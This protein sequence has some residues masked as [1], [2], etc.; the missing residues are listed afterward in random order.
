MSTGT[1]LLAL[2]DIDLALARDRAELAAMP[3]IAELAKKRRA[4]QKLKSDATKLYAQRKDLETYLA[5]LD[6]AESDAN[7]D[8]AI[9][10]RHTDTSDYRG[11]QQLE[12]ELSR[13]AKLLDKIAYDRAEY[14]KQLEEVDS[15]QT[16]LNDYIT[17]FESAVIADTKAAR[18]K[19]SD[20]QQR[21]DAGSA[22]RATIYDA[23][24][25]DAKTRY[26]AA[27]QR[28]NGLAVERLV[29]NVPSVCRTALQESSMSDLAHAADICECPYC[30]RILV[31]EQEE[32]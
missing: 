7:E 28:F 29:G 5:E 3:E 21:I 27:S 31:V 20:I 4:Y 26:D 14:T 11:V 22:K 17:K 6:Q 8:I 10:Q 9:A 23:L 19:A 1:S 12:Q 25:D 18:A 13:L 32:S 30:H 16:Y 15:K 24:P 2:Q